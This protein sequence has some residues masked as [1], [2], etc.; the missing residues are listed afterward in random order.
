VATNSQGISV[1]WSSV[2]L[3]EVVSVSVDGVTADT[4]EMTPRSSTS[5]DKRYRVADYDYGTVTIRCRGTTSMSTSNVGTS[6]TL[7]IS[8]N[9]TVIFSSTYAIFA[10]L[11]W[12]ASVGE[13]QEYTVTFKL[14]E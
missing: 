7:A 9:S 6:G 2:A 11:A 8:R 1:V 13:L 3:A 4:V 14:T 10:S 5:R 12:G